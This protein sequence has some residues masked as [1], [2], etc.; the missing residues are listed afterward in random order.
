M[1]KEIFQDR[2]RLLGM[3]SSSDIAQVFGVDTSTVSRWVSGAVPVPRWAGK[4]LDYLE[5][6]EAARGNAQEWERKY[7]ELASAVRTFRTVLQEV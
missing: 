3:R 1:S 2:C 5:V 4:L 7:Q 6:A